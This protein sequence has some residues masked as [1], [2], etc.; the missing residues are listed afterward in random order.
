MLTSKPR[1]FLTRCLYN[2]LLLLALFLAPVLPVDAAEP[3]ENLYLAELI[4]KGL[5][6]KLASEREWHLLLHYRKD[7]FG[8]YTSEQDDTGFFMSP[9]GKTDPQAELDATLT[10]FFSH[11][12][13]GRSKQPAQCAFIARYEWLRNQL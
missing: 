8:G 9:N 3:F 12:L 11:E 13:V 4:D 5:Q 1:P 2:F 10:Q 6:A 7:L